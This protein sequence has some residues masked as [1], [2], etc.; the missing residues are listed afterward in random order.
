MKI[1]SILS[2]PKDEA[3][4]RE[5]LPKV[6]YSNALIP[7]CT[8]PLLEKTCDD[9]LKYGFAAVAVYPTC[10]EYVIRRLEGSKVHS[11]IAVG[12]P[13]GNHLPEAKL[14]EAEVALDMGVKE[15][16][17]VMSIYR[18]LNNEY[19]YVEKDIKQ[20]V[21]A[22]AKYDVGVKMIIEV[23]FLNDVQKIVAGKIAV[24]AGVEYIKTCTGWWGR[25]NAHDI[26]MLAENFGDKAKIKASGGILSLEDMLT[27]TSLGASRCAGRIEIVNQLETMGFLP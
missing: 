17:V 5:L 9:A 11:Q 23:G 4:I 2:Y 15:I 21:D 19:A 14:R 13:S 6:D 8:L 27:Y 10:I 22:A 12:F 1:V 26:T 18:F 20:I 24:N 3:V 7:N 16:D 25:A